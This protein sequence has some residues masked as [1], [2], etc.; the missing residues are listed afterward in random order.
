MLAGMEFI[1]KERLD[2]TSAPGGTDDR[3]ALFAVDEITT[4]RLT[5]TPAVRYETSKITSAN[6]LVDTSTTPATT[7]P[8]TYEMDAVMGGLALSYD[9]GGGMS[10]FGSGAYTEGL[11]IIDDLGT[12][13]TSQRRLAMSEKSRTL[14][15]GAER[16]AADTF[17]PGDTLTLRGNFYRTTLWDIT[18]YTVAG[19]M[20]DDL[21]R[22]ETS[23]LELEAS[24]GR[25]NGF[26]MDFAGHIGSGTEFNPDGSKASWRNTAADRAQV[27]LGRKWT[28]NLDL[29]WELVHAADRRDSSGT[30]IADSLVH[31]LRATWRPSQGI[32]NGAEIRVGAENLTNADYVSHLSSPSRKAPG[33]TLKLTLSTTF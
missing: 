29:S 33:R 18:S 31:N 22:V 30:D 20:S 8:H 12:S 3:I 7:Y 19:S 23:G 11:P 32:L 13:A 24:Y 5:T 25:A 16:T 26:Y 15:F 6:D 14:E 28:E 9:L 10:V 21:E 17:A 2:A 27:T 1:Q 4:G